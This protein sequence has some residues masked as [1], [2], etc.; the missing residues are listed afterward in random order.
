MLYSLDE[1]ETMSWEA[2]DLEAALWAM[3]KQYREVLL[4]KETRGLSYDEIAAVSGMDRS[5]VA[6][7]LSAAR[8]QILLWLEASSPSPSARGERN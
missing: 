1:C 2:V 4:L 6:A 3:P 5:A 7:Q 8:R